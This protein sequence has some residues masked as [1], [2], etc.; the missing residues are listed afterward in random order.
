M[1]LLPALEASERFCERRRGALV[2]RLLGMFTGARDAELDQLIK[3]IHTQ[4]QTD[5]PRGVR[6]EDP[7]NRPPSVESAETFCGRRRGALAF[8]LLGLFTGARGEDLDWLIKKV[9]TQSL[10]ENTYDIPESVW[11]TRFGLL[12]MPLALLRKNWRWSPEERA[13]FQLETIDPPYFKRWFEEF[14]RR[15]PGSKRL[16][17]RAPA[18]FAGLRVTE[19]VGRSVRAAD[20]LTL[21]LLSPFMALSVGLLRLTDG[22][23]LRKSLRQALSIFVAYRAH[24]QRYP[25]RVFVTYA[26][27]LNHPARAL[28]LRAGCGARLFVVQNGERIAHPYFAYGMMD[29]Y[30]VFGRAYA[31]ILASMRVRAGAFTPIGALCLNERHGLI[32]KA[33]R[34]AGP[35]RWDVLFVDQSLWP[36]N[37]LNERSGRSLETIMARLNEYKRRHPNRRIA[38]QLRPYSKGE[39]HVKALVIE[40][41]QRLMSEPVDLLDNLGQGE[42]YRNILV[43]DVTL[44]FESTLGFEALMMG[45]KAMFVNFSGD[46]PESLCPDPRFQHEDPAADY[47]AFEAK[48]ES[49]LAMRLDDIPQVAHDRHFAFDGRVQERLAGLVEEAA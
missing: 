14:Y 44:T 36:H 10:P 40:T 16:V 30:F 2:F 25:C 49:I 17:P 24:A 38:Y 33:R 11:K 42:S 31:E 32:E 23:D 12:A 6:P 48:L 1:T 28:G 20:A 9:Y 27:E 15:L 41:V 4:S 39:A 3:K 29:R 37:G 5:A 35:L 47:A 19:P 8:R 34:D 26:D 18:D 21:A 43:T 13:D 7:M 22:A 45:R 46:P